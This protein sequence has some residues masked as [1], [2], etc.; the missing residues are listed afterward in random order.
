MRSRRTAL[1]ATVAGMV[2]LGPRVV[3]AQVMS[4]G[5]KREAKW[6]AEVYAGAMMSPT[7][8]AGDAA[9]FPIGSTF[10]TEQGASSRTNASWYFGDGATLFNE[11]NAQFA[12]RFNIR[13]PQ[14][15]PLDGMLTSAALGRRGAGAFGLRVT[16]RVTK[17]F[18]VEFSVDISQERLQMTTAA[19]DAVENA[20]ASFERGF[21]GLLATL[22]QTR[23]QVTSTAE[24]DEAAS[25]RQRTIT[26]ALTIALTKHRRFAVHALVGGGQRFG[27]DDAIEARL[28][29]HYQFRFLD[30]YPI[31]ESDT[32]TIRL[33]DRRAGAVGVVGG[34]VTTDLG[35][36]HGARA[37]VRVIV[38]GSGGLST[39]VEAA[40]SAQRTA[41]FVALPSNTS[42]SLQFSTTAS[43]RSSLG[44]SISGVKTF[45][46]S[47]LDTRILLTV[48]YFI[49][50]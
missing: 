28:R 31:D 40:A 21:S 32:V 9:A 48:G 30:T 37:G 1:I 38:G 26:G 13:F 10:R 3:S 22:P 45:T 8:T 5:P 12:S 50:F 24:I 43:E 18:G 36:R 41:P 27:R 47:G 44:G 11:V 33:A 14:L 23:L 2:A 39:S 34:G 16:R 42:P 6:T 17:R 49:R 25:T 7:P 20:R 15:A 4:P 19:K 35:A 29:G 46:G